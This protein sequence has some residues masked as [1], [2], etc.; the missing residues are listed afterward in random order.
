[1]EEAMMHL[2]AN[3]VC[4]IFFLMADPGSADETAILPAPVCLGRDGQPLPVAKDPV[5]IVSEVDRPVLVSNPMPRWPRRVRGCDRPPR[6]WVQAIVTTNGE[7][8]AA[9]L[10]KPL[11]QACS[12]LG[13]RAVEAVRKWKFRPYLRDG[14]PVAFHYAVGIGFK[15]E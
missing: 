4:L 8:C 10:L 9:N 13:E 2:S 6:I 11:P 14:V 5:S 15:R 1:M 12:T 3:V 7:I